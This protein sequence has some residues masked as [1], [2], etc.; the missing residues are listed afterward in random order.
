[1]RTAGQAVNDKP[2]AEIDLETRKLRAGLMLE[3]CLETINRGLGLAT[4]LTAE[5]GKIMKPPG[6]QKPN[7]AK[8][9]EDMK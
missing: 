5:G 4:V 8:V 3:E 6:Y 7:F 9:L 2:T 1:M